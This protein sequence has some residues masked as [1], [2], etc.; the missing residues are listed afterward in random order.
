MATL[1]LRIEI[2][3]RPTKYKFIKYK[4]TDMDLYEFAATAIGWVGKKKKECPDPLWF[5]STNY[6]VKI[7]MQDGEVK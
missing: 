4:K 1:K 6:V 3:S 5:L 7:E 2:P